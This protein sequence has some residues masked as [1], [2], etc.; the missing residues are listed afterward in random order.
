[1]HTVKTAEGGS[2]RLGFDKKRYAPGKEKE[3]A[4]LV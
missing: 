4:F 1:M 3:H 2:L